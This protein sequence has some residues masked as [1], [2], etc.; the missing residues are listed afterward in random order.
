M[1]EHRTQNLD[2]M[3]SGWVVISIICFAKKKPFGIMTAHK[4]T[5]N[6]IRPYSKLKSNTKKENRTHV[7]YQIDCTKNYIVQTKQYVKN[8]MKAHQNS[9]VGK[10]SEKTALKKHAEEERHNFDF[11][12]YKIL[13]QEQNEKK[14]LVYE[15]IFI[16]REKNCVNDKK[17]IENL[18]KI[19]NNL[20]K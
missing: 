18:S 3:F 12:N 14:R 16:K 8:R 1:R 6:L 7:V 15:M 20:L 9:V 4:N 11:N 10:N 13:R 2:K 19:Y 17:D 5:S